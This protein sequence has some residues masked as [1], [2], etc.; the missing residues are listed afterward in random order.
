MAAEKEML[1]HD[2]VRRRNWARAAALYDQLISAAPGSAQSTR[3]QKDQQIACLLGR[4]ECLLELGKYEGCL[5][6]AY[7]VLTLLAEQTECLASVSRARRWLVH[8]LFKMHKYGDAEIFLSKWINELSGQQIFSDISKTLER[9]KSI[10]QMIMNGQHKAQAQKIP[11]ARLEDEMAILDTKLDHWATNNLPLDK[12]SK[13][14]SNKGLK[15]REQQQQ[16]HQQQQN[17]T[18]SGSGSYASSS[19]N[20]STGSS[21]TISSSNS[22]LHKTNDLLAAMKLTAGK[23]Q[24]ASADGPSLDAASG[25]DQAA[26]STT[27]SYCAI[28]FLTRNELRQHCQ[29]EA[30]QKVIMSDEGRDWKWRPP[31]RGYTLDTYSLCETF[32]DAHTCHYG[33]QCVEAHGQDELNEW[34]ERFEYRRMRVQKACEKELYGKSYTEQVLERWI[35]ATAPERVMC[36]RVPEIDA[37]CEQQ[38]VTSISSKTSKREWLFQLETKQPLKAVALL[39]DAHRN[40]F[41]L[42]SIK[43]GTAEASASAQ[44]ELKSDQEWVAAAAATAT[45]TETQPAEGEEESPQPATLNHEVTV[46]F[47]T[48]IYGTFRQAICFDVGQEPLLVRHLCVDVLPVNDAEKIEE[49]KRDIINNSATR[50]DVAN[51]Q[52]TRFE[53]TIG[54]HLKTEAYLSD[55]DHE[56]ELLERY[57]CPLAATFTLTQSTIVEKRLTQNNYRS[58]IHELLYVEEI[59]RYEQIA[60]Y[61]VRTRL[62]VASNYILTPAGMATSTAKYSLAGELFA[63]MRLGKDISE[64]TSP[65]RLILSNCS[66]V[67]ISAPEDAGRKPSPSSASASAFDQTRP[68]YEALI[69]DK[70][71]NVIY[72]K[73]SAK[74][75]E[76]MALQADTELDVDIQF[77][78]NRMPYCEWHNAVDKITDFRLIFPATELEPNIPWTP[79]KQWADACEPKL[80]AKQRE[81][82]NAITTALSI[83]LPPI[84]LIGPFGT[85]KTYTLA[86]A[87]KQLLAQPE[88]KILIC[89]HSNSAADLYIK[90]YLH[91]WIEEGLEE[92][93]PLRVYYHKRW[94]ATVN[95]VVQKYC[96]TDGVGNF[97]RPTLEDIM[98]HRIVVVTLSISME[99][100]T[101]GLPK[102]L[103]THIFLDEAAQAMECEAIMPLA[104]ANDSTRIVLAGDHMQMSPELFSAFAKERKLHIS[105]LE[106]LYDH[107]PSNFPC[108]ILLCENYRAHEAIIRFTS[109]LFYEQKL[110][111]SG[112]QPRHE[113]F[114]PLTFFTTRG[115]DVQD[116]NSTAF[117][118]N[119]EVYE[120]VERVSELR[121]RWP[122]AWGKLNDT[123]IGIMTPY[124]DQVFRIR[125]EL[126]KR[127]MGGISVER[128]LNVQGKQFR[129]VF[130]STV[131]TRRTCMPQGSGPGVACAATIGDADTDYGFLSNSKLLNTAITRA[132]SLVAVVGDPVALCS[133]GRCRKVW[134]RFI[135]I[136]DEHKSLFGLT[137]S[138]LRSQLDGVELKRGYVL[139]PLAPEFVPRALQPEAYLR[140]QAA[141]YLNGPQHGHGSH[142]PPGPPAHYAN[143]AG[144]LGPGPAAAHQMNQMAAAMAANQQLSHMYSTHMAAMMA[145]AAAVSGGKSANGPVPGPPP[146]YGGGGHM[147]MRGPPPNGAPQPPHLRGMPGPGP[148]GPPPAGGAPPPPYGQYAAM[149][150]WRPPIAPQQQPGVQGQGQG[151]PQNP[152]ASLWGPP[153][154][155]N[156]WSVLPPNNKQ[157]QP[158]SVAA[159]GRGPGPGPGS[160]QPPPPNANSSL[161]LR[162]GSVPPPPPNAPPAA[163]LLRNPSELGYLAKK[164]LYNQ[165]QAPLPP[166]PHHLYGPPQ[167]QQAPPPI[168]GMQRGSSVPNGPMSPMENGPPLPYLRHNGSGYN[169]YDKPLAPPQQQQQQQPP[170]MY[171]A[172][173]PS[174]NSLRF[175][176]P[177]HDLLPPNVSIYEMAF[178]PKEEQYKWYLKLLETVGQEGANKFADMLRQVMATLQQQQGHQ[179]QLK[180]PP[181]QQMVNN[182]MLNNPHVTGGGGGGQGQRPQY[183]MMYPQNQ[184][185]QPLQQ[186]TVEA[187]PPLENFN[188]QIDL[189]F[190]SIMNGANDIAQ[191][192]L[193]DVLGMVASTASAP[194]AGHSLSNGLNALE[195]QQQQ[196]QQSRL[197]AMMQQQQQQQQQQAKI[198]PGPGPG[199]YAGHLAGGPPQ[200]GG[201]GPGPGAH[202]P[203]PNSSA[204]NLGGVTSNF[205]AGNP[206][207]NDKPY[208][209]LNMHINVGSNNAGVSGT[210]GLLSNGN[211]V[212]LYRRQALTGNGIGI[213]NS[214]NN[215]PGLDT[216]TNLIEALFHANNAVADHSV[217]SSD[218]VQGLLY[219][220]FNALKGGHEMDLFQSMP[221]PVPH[222]EANNHHQQQQQASSA[223][224]TYAA[225][226]S[227]GP[228][229]AS[230]SSGVG[231]GQTQSQPH[232]APTA[233][234]SQAGSSE[235]LEKDPFAA[236]RELGQAT[237]GFYNYFQ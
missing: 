233:K 46:E 190:N 19:S 49:I 58:R 119:A 147:G 157:Q 182:P 87:I 204:N 202:Q 96:I 97:K 114:Y 99:L 228:Q 177:S 72:L 221:L 54:T 229:A 116:K 67:Y 201:P 217:K 82:V 130:L 138:N 38:L 21:S 184:A 199:L 227:Q 81:A 100:A 168:Q 26:P 125:S 203:P 163:Q 98:R 107:Y 24:P 216:S 106:R 15:K 230:A 173:Q 145:A 170:F 44:V 27:C 62:T 209:N 144:M 110:V 34:K 7:K 156:P 176:P 117:Y 35:Q 197:F 69:E 192:I 59:A 133:I 194:G 132:Q 112:K 126:R 77:Q 45:A 219:N 22:N 123:S 111:A 61:N 195:L 210:N 25:G 127:R 109:E 42:K 220:N 73:L 166:P 171:G 150:H 14:L 16:Q 141:L 43:L 13:L 129:A 148:P 208:N 79:K 196:Q 135:E 1:A 113:R 17:G 155:T 68:V 108:K 235:L 84:L 180:Q 75:V 28:N 164:T 187:S 18:G 213:G 80:N 154:Q 188:H 48:E 153:P 50:W 83:K 231:V 85:G 159:P 207:L 205:M 12:Y 218:H 86:Q 2:M 122:S 222:S 118:N 206:L 162:G 234:S 151:Q 39:Q 124:A 160:L 4:C 41:A 185:P 236:I 191:P 40:H 136:C 6:D 90:E 178:N 3:V 179:H 64:D 142:A 146:H 37:K 56:R 139:N 120:V 55:L 23:H 29:T 134:E 172:K 91:P 95:G 53:T 20:S 88:A 101:L 70:G 65:G 140:D 71:K 31:P 32:S 198:P 104:L 137:W 181:H 89:T 232:A 76:A 51:T 211:S 200:A 223:A 66:S 149:Q 214:C 152:N 93:T 9:Y 143:A 94:S 169:S 161:P 60:R 63:L 115:E 175:G 78:L 47:R 189:V 226:L 74:C 10:I 8:A 30:H 186:Q 52:L 183:P 174:P 128:V 225:V 36:E 224:T 102:G 131:R 165:G 33:A 57:P 215:M 158:P 121:K 105:L 237:T 92:A 212:P 103:F 5:A 167:Q 193:R 11:H